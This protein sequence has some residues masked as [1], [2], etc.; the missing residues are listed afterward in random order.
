MKTVIS[1]PSSNVSE[2]GGSIPA[3]SR[4][5]SSVMKRGDQE[6]TA[7]WEVERSRNPARQIV[8][9]VSDS[10]SKRILNNIIE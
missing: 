10:E 1:N 5:S 6:A 7:P 9:G 2:G 8:V 3:A 4:L